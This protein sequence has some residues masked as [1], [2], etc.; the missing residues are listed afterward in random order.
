M[1]IFIG[2]ISEW[3]SMVMNQFRNKIDATMIKVILAPGEF[4][5]AVSDVQSE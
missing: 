2:L 3:I 1:V 4:T 5:L